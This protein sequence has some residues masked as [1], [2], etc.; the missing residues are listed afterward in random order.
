MIEPK[1]EQN[2]QTIIS[3]EDQIGEEI[4]IDDSSEIKWTS[5]EKGEVI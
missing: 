5:L 3:D 2:D 1:V 4:I